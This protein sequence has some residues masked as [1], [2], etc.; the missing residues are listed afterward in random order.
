MNLQRKANMFGMITCPKCHEEKS[1][2]V[3]NDG[4]YECFRCGY[5]DEP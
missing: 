2:I 5:T 4:H 1:L 3:T